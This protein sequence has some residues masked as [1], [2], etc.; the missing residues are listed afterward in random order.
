[1]KE[2]ALVLGILVM[3]TVIAVTSLPQSGGQEKVDCGTGQ[4]RYAHRIE[5]IRK[6]LHD[7]NC[8][9]PCRLPISI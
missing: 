1:M 8:Y 3:R 7:V 9:G 4:E 2:R 5:Q 6:A